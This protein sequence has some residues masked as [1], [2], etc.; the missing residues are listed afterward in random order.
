M[1]PSDFNHKELISFVD[2]RKGHDFR[3]SINSSKIQT[4]LGWS[5]KTKFDDGIQKTI[6]WFSEKN[7][8]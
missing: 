1:Y 4:K 2:D 7:K 5:P 6:K 3:Y 8:Y